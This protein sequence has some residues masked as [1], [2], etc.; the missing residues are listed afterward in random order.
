M[1]L[2]ELCACEHIAHNFIAYTSHFSGLALQ[3]GIELGPLGV[4]LK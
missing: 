3:G 1:L 4:G 2:L